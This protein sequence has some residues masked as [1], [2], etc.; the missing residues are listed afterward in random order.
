MSVARVT[1]ITSSSSKSF[2]DAIEEG[3]ARAAK[4]LKNVEGAW[5]KD[6]KI[7]VQGGKIAA[8]RVNMKV[9]F[10]LTD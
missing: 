4:T 8:Y 2:Q 6:Q 10:I 9:T 1:E 3:I 7:V 5:I